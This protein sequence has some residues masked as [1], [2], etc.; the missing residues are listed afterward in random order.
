MALMECAG[1][2]IRNSPPLRIGLKGAG[3]TW[4][5]F[6]NVLWSLTFCDQSRR[7]VAL[8]G[9]APRSVI[10]NS[11]SLGKVLVHGGQEK[12]DCF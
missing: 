10:S 7:P 4:S 5:G 8:P 12:A 6:A 1:S 9:R 3:L 11:R 2:S